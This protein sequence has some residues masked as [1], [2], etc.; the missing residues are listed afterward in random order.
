MK[1]LKSDESDYENNYMTLDNF[2][3]LKKE[4]KKKSE[5]ETQNQENENKKDT[6]DQIKSVTNNIVMSSKNFVE[7]LQARPLA[8]ISNSAYDQD[9]IWSNYI[10]DWL[11]KILV[12]YYI[13]LFIMGIFR[14]FYLEENCCEPCQLAVTSVL[15]FLILGLVDFLKP[16]ISMSLVCMCLPCIISLMANRT[17]LNF[18]FGDDLEENYDVDEMNLGYRNYME[19]DIKDGTRKCRICLDDYEIGEAICVLSC[20]P[21]HFFHQQ[22]AISVLKNQFLCPICQTNLYEQDVQ[23]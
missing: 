2:K 4:K 19:E 18:I 12:V 16:I 14:L 1:E 7:N 3:V 22:C 11:D 15:L 10:I 9:D 17:F 20:N 13:F 8:I 5:R 23:P 21:D 6:M